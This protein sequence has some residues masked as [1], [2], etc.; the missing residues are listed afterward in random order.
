MADLDRNLVGLGATVGRALDEQQRLARRVAQLETVEAPAGGDLPAMLNEADI[1]TTNA[2][3]Y[4]DAGSVLTVPVAAT[5]TVVVMASCEFRTNN[6]SYAASLR[7]L[8]DDAQVA[9]AKSTASTGY[10]QA[11]WFE[12]FAGV[13]AD[14]TLHFEVKSYDGSYYGYAQHK[15][16]SAWVYPE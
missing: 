6:A 7:F 16:I 8:K 12:I 14:I 4:V 3:S 10:V 9:D 11:I 15:H 1:T 13:A 5:S 2:G